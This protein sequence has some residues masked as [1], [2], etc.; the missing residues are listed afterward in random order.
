MQQLQEQLDAQHDTATDPA[1][2]AAYKAAELV[3]AKA[4]ISL[5]DV[6]GDSA[7][8]ILVRMTELYGQQERELQRLQEAAE[9]A[10]A[11]RSVQLQDLARRTASSAD[12]SWQ[13]PGP[14]KSMHVW[15]RSWQQ[16]QPGQWGWN[17]AGPSIRGNRPQRLDDRSPGHWHKS[18]SGLRSAA[19]SGPEH[20]DGYQGGPPAG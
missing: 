3:S 5:Y 17:D 16:G 1:A 8:E 2:I 10:R 15:D 6:S 7:I 4:I 9:A 13:G 19:P 12:D 20:A 18:S 11:Q 14:G